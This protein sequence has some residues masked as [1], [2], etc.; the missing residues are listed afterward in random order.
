MVGMIMDGEITMRTK[1]KSF[2]L[3]AGLI[4]LLPSL[5][6]QSSGKGVTGRAA[7]EGKWYLKPV[8]SSDT[9]TG[10]VPEISFDIS[11]GH[12]TG[13]TGCNNMR[14]DVRVTDSTM[15]FSEQI[16]TTRMSCVGYNEAAF[17]KNLIRINGYKIQDGMLVLMVDG[18]EVSRWTRKKIIPAKI[19]RT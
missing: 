9:T 6:A 7:V 11:G 3:I 1:V 15:A 18:T 19:L 16:V 2:I 12:F 8:L 17:L 4:G 10:K 5:R 14:G 13:N